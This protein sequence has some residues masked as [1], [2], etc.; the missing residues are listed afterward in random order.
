MSRPLTIC[1]LSTLML[2]SAADDN[3]RAA[4][5]TAPAP[6][7]PYSTAVD[8]GPLLF[9]SGQVAID[10]MTGKLDTSRSV[11]DQTRQIWANIAAVLE[12][13]CLNLGDIV[14]AQ[15]FLTDIG[16]FAEMNTA[17]AAAMGS[18][19]P[20]RTTVA[21]AALPLGAAIEIAVVAKR[22]PDQICER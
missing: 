4:T 7:G 5:P 6:V 12:L 13:H 17:Y 19:R 16:D 3:A 10:P 11:A 2:L 8:A 18:S 15:V 14:Q 20:A 9:L 1:G 22:P 21:V